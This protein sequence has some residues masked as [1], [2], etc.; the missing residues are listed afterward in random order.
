[1][2]LFLSLAGLAQNTIEV[3]EDSA[4]TYQKVVDFEIVDVNP[5]PIG[6]Y[7]EMYNQISSNLSNYKLDGI[8][9]LDCSVVYSCKVFVQFLVTKEGKMINHE[10]FKSIAA[11]YDSVSLAT[12]K[13]LTTLW[14]PGIKDGKPVDTRMMIP[15]SFK[16]KKQ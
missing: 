8:D 3:L 11:P 6:G 16:P 13:Q 5:Q 15:I 9:T 2:Q 7:I 12:I 1:M 10:I 14:E 4:S